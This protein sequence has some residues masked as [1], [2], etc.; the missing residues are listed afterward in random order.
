MMQPKG[1]CAAMPCHGNERTEFFRPHGRR[2]L[3]GHF[4]DIAAQLHPHI[5]NRRMTSKVIDDDDLTQSI[6]R[7]GDVDV[8]IFQALE[9]G[10]LRRDNRGRG[11][12][13]IVPNASS[14]G[15]CMTDWARIWWG[16][17]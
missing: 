11:T 4:F 2:I 17:P 12:P 7:M 3:N 9:I 16:S 1:R 6:G 5:P 10:R 8:L 13:R 14:A 15:S